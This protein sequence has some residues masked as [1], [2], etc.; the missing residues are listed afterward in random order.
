MRRLGFLL[1]SL[2]LFTACQKNYNKT[3]QPYNYLPNETVSIIKINALNDFINSIEN[4]DIL[5]SVYNEDLK[6]ASPILKNLNSNK[7]LYIGFWKEAE[8]DSK[9]IILTENNPKLFLIDSIPNHM[10]ER[11]VDFNIDKTQIDSTIVYHKTFGNVFALSN[12]LEILKN[13]KTEKNTTSELK[14]LIETT[15]NKSVASIL[16]KSKNSNYSKLLFKTIKGKDEPSSY[17]V[18]DINYSDKSLL[19]NGVIKSKDSS[20]NYIDAFRYTIPQKTSSPSLAPYYTKELLSITYDNFSVFNKNLNQLNEQ[21]IDSTQTFLNFTNEIAVIDKALILHT[22]DP[23]LVLETINNKTNY[24]TFKAIEIYRFE[25]PDFF[26]LRLQPIITFENAEFFSV[27]DNFVVFSSSIEK[28]KTILSSALNNNTLADSEAFI[29]MNLNLSDEASLFIFKDAERLSDILEEK[30]TN[31]NANAV[32]FIYED[33]YAHVNGVIQKFK[34]RAASNS[35][36][37]AF[38]I[39]LNGDIIIPPQTLKNHLTNAHDIA[40]QDVDNMLYLISSAGNI[41]WKKQLKN[42]II[43]KIE[44]LDTY[45]NGRLQLA[46]TTPNRLYI[47][48]RNGKDVSQFPLKFKDAISQPLSVFDYDKRKNYRLLVTQGENLL[49]YDTKGKSVRGFKYKNNGSTIT[50]QPKH[51]RINSKD[52]ITFSTGETLKILNRQGDNRI[53]VKDKIRFSKNEVYLYQNKFTTTN[54]LGQLIQ[55]DTKGKLTSKNL[56]LS[57]KHTIE[58]TSKTLVSMTDNKLS[59][60]SRSIDLD[61]GEYTAPKIFYINDKIYVTTTDLQ[62]KKVYLFDSQAK[63]IPNFPVFG[64][65]AAKLEELDKDRGLELICQSDSKTITVY[66]LH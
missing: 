37:E 16:F 59:I 57:D 5:S 27:Y 66:K 14:K 10:S 41:L 25:T 17:S 18:L 61:Y 43:G 11:L 24:E 19:Y 47:L 46:F 32:Q 45:K 48:D 23:D 51:F 52:Y 49:M 42:K 64:T 8:K 62:A 58:T 26:E 34:K 39:T 4:H 21:T 3:K 29:N 65:S 35:V 30:V 36:T 9:Y 33:N 12:D 40:I 63:P 28:L 44:Q 60:K 15:D 13:L 2:T 22:L 20:L 7:E 1:I 55:V 38:T 53:N 54:T 31:Y 50:S 6:I 56:N